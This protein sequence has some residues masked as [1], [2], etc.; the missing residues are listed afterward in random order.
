[1][2][3]PTAAQHAGL[4]RTPLYDLHVASGA[5]MVAFAGY[6]MPIQYPPGIMKEHLH[7]RAHAGLF[8]VSHMGQIA[9]RPRNGTM[10]D[11]ATALERLVP[12]DVVG[13]AAG[14]QRYA[15]F[16]NANGGV[17]DDL[18]IAHC[19]DRFV[20][21]VN[22]SRKTIDAQFLRTALAQVCVVEMLEDRALLALQG[23]E[24]ESVLARF[25]PDSGAMR[26]MDVR[27]LMIAGSACN[28]TR[29]G[30]TGEDGFEISVAASEAEMLARVLLDN[31]SVALAGLG[32]RDSL[33]IE[34]G[35]CLYGSDIDED[36]T[37]IEAALKWAIPKVRRR[38]GARTGGFPGADVVLAQLDDG[39][40]RRRVGLRA[41]GRM[42]VRG[43]TLL[44]ATA[45]AADPVGTVTSG[46][47]GPS[48]GGPVA[49]GYL[50][51]AL[52]ARGTHLF[53]EVRGNAVPIE[54]TDLPF[55]PH[56]YKRAHQE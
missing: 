34:A 2:T 49:M 37:S 11:I 22:A 44:F 41:Q 24:A 28:V 43:G 23:P 51:H 30:Y 9:L 1:M 32:A 21:I 15:F 45:S 12:V 13:L 40:L 36:T 48:V 39:P 7:T 47:F 53:A 4:M 35:L 55:I 3:V 8:D 38:A 42:P 52:S 27:P 29:S 26:F 50:P 16:T 54:V 33:R 6:E 19:D 10:A 31:A 20:L 14:R 46:G 25:A 56:R 17:I 18:M 5:R